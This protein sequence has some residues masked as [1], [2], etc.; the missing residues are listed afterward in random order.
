M[1]LTNENIEKIK[2]YKELLNKGRYGNAYE[3][4]DTWNEVYKDEKNFTPK[5]PVLCGTCLRKLISEMYSDMEI[6]LREAEKE[7]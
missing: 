4:T 5:K 1:I 3:I 7:T 2:K 6:V